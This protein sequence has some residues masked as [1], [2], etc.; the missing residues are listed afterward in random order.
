MNCASLAA[1]FAALLALLLLALAIRSFDA[2]RGTE[3]TLFPM[4]LGAVATST[5]LCAA[6]FPL[7]QGRHGFSAI[8]AE[9][10]AAPPQISESPAV[11]RR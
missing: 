5:A 9:S 8:P 2:Q 3:G 11:I 10:L 4:D 7:W 1:V 6:R